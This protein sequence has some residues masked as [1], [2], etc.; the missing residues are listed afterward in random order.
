MPIRFVGE[1]MKLQMKWDKA[2]SALLFD[3]PKGKQKLPVVSME[4]LNRAAAPIEQKQKTFTVGKKRMSAS[5]VR[6]ICFI[7]RSG[8]MWRWLEEDRLRGQ[9]EAYGGYQQGG[10]GDERDVFRCIYEDEL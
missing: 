4:R 1:A 6:S 3:T 8:S 9:P 7:R 2:A 10:G 5:I